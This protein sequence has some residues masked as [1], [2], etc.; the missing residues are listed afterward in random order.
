MEPSLPHSEG[1]ETIMLVEDEA[2]VRHL[3]RSVLDRFGYNVVEADCGAAALALWEQNG[4]K[5]D[6]LLTDMIMPG[7]I[8]GRDLADKLRQTRP[9]LKVVYTS[10]YSPSRAGQDLKILEGLKFVP[11]P[12]SPNQ[13]IRAIQTSLNGCNESQGSDIASYQTSQVHKVRA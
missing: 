2:P 11:K 3:T 10:G 1:K 8:T 7:G 13:L 12:F 9:D 4:S 5:V 6:L